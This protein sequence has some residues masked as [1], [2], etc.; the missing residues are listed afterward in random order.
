MIFL[1]LLMSLHIFADPN[2]VIG[3]VS[4]GTLVTSGLTT[5]GIYGMSEY[6][7]YKANNDAPMLEAQNTARAIQ[8]AEERIKSLEAIPNRTPAQN[9][10]LHQDKI[11][12]SRISDHGPKQV[13]NLDSQNKRIASKARTWRKAGT[14]VGI[15]TIALSAFAHKATSA[16]VPLEEETN[17]AVEEI[18]VNGE[19]DA[20]QITESIPANGSR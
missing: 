8:K 9:L 7:S 16:Q 3:K 17:P 19:N 4:N 15:F 2:D 6:L 10:Q 13:S 1:S 12:L 5:L 18:Q 11:R 20:H 14:G